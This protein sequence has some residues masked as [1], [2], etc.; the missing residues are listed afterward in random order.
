MAR[1][2]GWQ[3]RTAG[4]RRRSPRRRFQARPDA[5]WHQ[6]RRSW[7]HPRRRSPSPPARPRGHGQRRAPARLTRERGQGPV[8]EAL[9]GFAVS[10]A[11]ICRAHPV[12]TLL[13][14]KLHSLWSRL[15]F[16]PSRA[17]AALHD[18]GRHRQGRPGSHSF[19]IR[20]PTCR[21]LAATAASCLALN[22]WRIVQARIGAPGPSWKPQA[23]GAQIAKSPPIAWV[24]GY[25]GLGQVLARS[26]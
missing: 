12:R 13:P 25:R 19:D 15:A 4:K 2:G 6:R 8:S 7:P 3:F 16:L 23:S 9:R 10:C 20:P 5:P 1:P 24:V 11:E 22:I 14:L 26:W 21:A 17:P 18:L